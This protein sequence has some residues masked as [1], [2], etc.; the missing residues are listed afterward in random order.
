MPHDLEHDSIARR[1]LLGLGWSALALTATGTFAATIRFL[2]PNV[3]FEPPAAF[4][5]G[6]PDDYAPG[7]VTF[8]AERKI[9]VIRGDDGAFRALT[10]TCPH[11]RCVVRWA[12]DRSVYECPCHG[13]E[14][15]PRGKVVAG[16]SPTSLEWYELTLAPDGRLYVNTLVRVQPDYRLNV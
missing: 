2:L 12:A 4:K 7:S 1:T 10:A 13:S 15:S 14:F 16:P 11:L 9:F 5:I 8:V 6:K 3:L